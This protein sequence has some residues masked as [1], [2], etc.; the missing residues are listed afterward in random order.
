MLF[1][2]EFFQNVDFEKYQQATKGL[3]NFPVGKKKVNKL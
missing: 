2:K 1:L 3:I